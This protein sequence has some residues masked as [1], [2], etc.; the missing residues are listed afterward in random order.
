VQGHLYAMVDQTA[1]LGALGVSVR[2]RRGESINVGFSAKFDRDEFLAELTG[3]GLSAQAEWID[4]VARYG[5]FL[6]RR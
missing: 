5:I 1:R 4:P 2:L 6:L 3:H